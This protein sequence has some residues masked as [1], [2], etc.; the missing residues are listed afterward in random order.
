MAEFKNDEDF[1]FGASSEKENEELAFLNKESKNQDGIYRPRPEDSADPRGT[2]YR[3]IIRFLRNVYKDGS[4]AGPAAIQ[5]HVH[6]ADFKNY[7]EL[8]GYY[9]C[10]KNTSKQTPCPLCTTYWKLNKSNN[11][12]DVENSKLIKRSTKYYSY[13]MVIE[14]EQH[15]ELVGKILVYPYGTKIL[16]KINAEKN[17]EVS[18]DGSKCNVFDFVTGKDFRLV[19]KIKKT[20][21][22]DGRPGPPVDMPNYDTSTFLTSTPLKIFS[23]KSQKFVTPPVEIIDGKPAITDKKWQAKIKEVL[24][25]RPDNVDLSNHAPKPLTDEQRANVERIISILTGNE[26]VKAERVAKTSSERA[27]VNIVDDDIDSIFDF[28]D[29]DDD[30]I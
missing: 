6:Y 25:N 23:E 12:A 28:D 18:E 7:P 1:L 29:E 22:P 5:K 10:E 15:P 3:A 24:M 20:P 9:D 19:I 13:I 17:G 4:G 26:V 16:E 11:S 27:P 21:P 8:S 14:D 30:G 2:G